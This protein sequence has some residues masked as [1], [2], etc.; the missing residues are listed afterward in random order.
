MAGL[1]LLGIGGE[2]Q[3]QDR[4]LYYDSQS[5]KFVILKRLVKLIDIQSKLPYPHKWKL[6]WK[7]VHW[8]IFDMRLS[9]MV[10]SYHF[11]TLVVKSK[12]MLTEKSLLCSQT[13]QGQ[14]T[15]YQSRGIF[16]Q[17]CWISL[18]LE[19]QNVYFNYQTK[20]KSNLQI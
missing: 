3:M 11:Q 7:E 19:K 10:Y 14:M 1:L 6:L 18:K 12:M 4:F 15:P 17:T 16:G 2:F 9:Q 20:T 8:L 13:F 5:T